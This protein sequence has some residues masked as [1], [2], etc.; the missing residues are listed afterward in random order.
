MP[1]SQEGLR[2][3]A[4]RRNRTL[5]YTNRSIFR[6][7]DLGQ[8]RL[9]LALGLPLAGSHLAQFALQVTDTI[10]LGWYGVAD[11]AAGV[12]GAA[13]FFTL[14]IFGTGFANAVMPMVATNAASDN[15]AEVRRATR[16]GLWL[17]VGFG[18][19]VLP[20]FWWSGPLLRA[21]DQPPEVAALAQDYLRILGFSMVPALVV[22]VIKNFLAALQRT[23]VVLWVTVGAVFVNILA[24][25]SLI[26]GNL[27]MPEMGVRGAAY[28]SV[29]VHSLSAL[30]LMAY[31]GLLPALRRYSLWQRL[32]R[33]DWQAMGAVWRLGWPIGVALVAESGLFA[34]TAVMMGW[35]GTQQLAA[36][37]IALEI[38]AMFFMIHL[39]LSNAATVI[40]GRARGHHDQDALRRGAAT[41]VAVSMG[42]AVLT[43]VVYV[44]FGPWMVGLFLAPDEPQRAAIIAIGYALV[45]V[46][47]LFQLADAAQVMA[48]GLLRG[49]QDTRVPML[50]AAFSYWVAGLGSSYL[51]GFTLG[52]GGEGIWFGLVIGLTLA[53]VMLMW[54]FWRGPGRAPPTP[55]QRP[56]V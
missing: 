26:F 52:F 31:A 3:C 48:M 38:T 9:V 32:W 13:V 42:V 14:F 53:A 17:S 28:A 15:D 37:G 4:R 24:N 55:V 33:P 11:L 12:L 46:A 7:A 34:A 54:R 22:M 39:G 1:G 27:G 40:V 43:M 50:I 47:A 25:W 2:A 8:V 16:M 45:L 23:Q 18:L 41:A 10:M 35:L 51:L 5:M 29:L 21:L 20:I 19:A 6:R 36:H 30:A 44:I 56:A 49:V